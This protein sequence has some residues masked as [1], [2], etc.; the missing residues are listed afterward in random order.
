M[1]DTVQRRRAKTHL[2]FLGPS[3]CFC[4]ENP[5]PLPKINNQPQ[6]K[7]F[8][9]LYDKVKMNCGVYDTNV[10]I[11]PEKIHV[12]AEEESEPNL[13]LDIRAAVQPP[14]PWYRK[15]LNNQQN[16]STLVIFLVLANIVLTVILLSKLANGAPRAYSPDQGSLYR[17]RPNY[18]RHPY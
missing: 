1:L 17:Y 18:Y 4:H 15:L 10:T 2:T 9:I 6:I 11:I 13:D 16:I 5:Q 8:Q 14:C 12:L 3:S 7:Y